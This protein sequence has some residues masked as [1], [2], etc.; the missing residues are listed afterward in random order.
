MK[1]APVL[2][3]AAYPQTDTGD[4]HLVQAHLL[5]LDSPAVFWFQHCVDDGH[6]VI[7]DNGVIER[8]EPDVGALLEMAEEIK[9]TVVIVPDQF[10]DGPASI[11]LFTKWCAACHAQADYVMCV[12]HGRNPVAWVQCLLHMES[13]YQTEICSDP[14]HLLVGVPKVLDRLA[15]G[16]TYAIR[17]LAMAEEIDLARLH[18]LGIWNTPAGA[19][20][21]ARAHP[22][23]SGLDSTLPF[24]LALHKSSL[25][26]DSPKTVVT[27]RYWDATPTR[28]Q[29][30]LTVENITNMKELLCTA[31]SDRCQMRSAPTVPTTSEP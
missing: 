23:V 11:K 17:L 14:S 26:A 27:S 19:L 4:Y 3:P 15:G 25:C 22:G 2:P 7:L 16:R 6:T 30:R 5:A 1:F 12:P 31:T 10:D 28:E 9:P 20:E 13:I 21:T 8:G 29:I 24:A 18:L